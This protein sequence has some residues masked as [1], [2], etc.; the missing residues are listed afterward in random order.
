MNNKI[1]LFFAEKVP[2]PGNKAIVCAAET[3]C[4]KI[5]CA[6]K[7]TPEDKIE[8]AAGPSGTSL[9]WRLARDSGDYCV[10]CKDDPDRMHYKLEC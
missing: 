5:M 6:P 1:P 7:G 10:Q 3:L 2:E 9:G 8:L 4:V